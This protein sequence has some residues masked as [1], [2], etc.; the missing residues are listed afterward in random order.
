M[1]LVAGDGLMGTTNEI[2]ETDRRKLF[3]ITGKKMVIKDV[4]QHRPEVAKAGIY[5]VLAP[6]EKLVAGG[7]GIDLS[8]N[9]DASPDAG[10]KSVVEAPLDEIPHQVARKN[11]G[12]AAR[13]E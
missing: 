9:L 1:V 10:R 3:P 2:F 12:I 7:K 13:K 6:Q 8:M 5:T 11:F 4:H